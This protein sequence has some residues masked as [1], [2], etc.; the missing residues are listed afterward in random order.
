MPA[1]AIAA[2]PSRQFERTRART[3]YST[4]MV[5]VGLGRGSSGDDSKNRKITPAP[6]IPAFVG[7]VEQF[8]HINLARPI[9]VEDMAR[10]ARMS[11]FHFSRLF[12]QARGIS[13]GR[14]LAKLRLDLAMQLLASSDL[15]LDKIAN[16]G[17][18]GDANYLCKVF[19][20]SYGVSPGRFRALSSG[21]HSRHKQRQQ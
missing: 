11:R 12:K 14:Y 2:E 3:T 10:V 9:G 1:S 20:T 19:R 6:A 21:P 4:C 7:L 16:L 13:P 15:T 18:Y 17:G 5:G 8:C